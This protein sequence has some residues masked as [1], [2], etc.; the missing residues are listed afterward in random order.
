[1]LHQVDLDQNLDSSK[2]PKKF[3]LRSKIEFVYIASGMFLDIQMMQKSNL[4]VFGVVGK[5][6]EGSCQF[7]GSYHC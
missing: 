2:S 6:F 5:Q 3:F 4:Q 1:M 7:E